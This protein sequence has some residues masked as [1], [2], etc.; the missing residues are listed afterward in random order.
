MIR[1]LKNLALIAALILIT[2]P[3]F[4]WGRRIHSAIAYIAEQHLTS[5]AKKTI[6]EILDGKSMVYY[7]S[8]L[9]DY[10]KQ[11][12]IEY[13]DEN[14][15][16]T[17]RTIPHSFKT[18]NER[19]VIKQDN[20]EAIN[21]IC[22]SITVLED[23]KNVD[24]STRLAAMQCIIHLVGDIHCPAHVKFSD[25]DKKN[26]DKKYDATKVIFGNDK[27]RMHSIWD[28][29]IIDHT[30]AGGVYDLAY[31]A[32]R[33]TKE[34]I[35][36]IQKGDPYDWGQEIADRTACV[37]TVRN[38][39]VITSEYMLK[40]RELALDQIQRAGLRLAKVMN[41]LFK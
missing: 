20:G 4:G 41:N 37:W 14:G 21:I 40:H 36:E 2:V 16:K 28:T 11:M 24:D 30:T 22:K 32:D 23:Y 38:G 33:A 7:G 17:I 29:K 1:T 19:N 6:N 26:P 3:S 27:A 35:K 25:F 5:K 34:E 10:R 15:E 31:L 9:D 39:D 13:I 8:W 12:T 18:D